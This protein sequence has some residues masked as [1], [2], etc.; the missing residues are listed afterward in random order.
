MFCALSSLYTFFHYFM[1]VKY[2]TRMFWLI[3]ILRFNIMMLF[4]KYFLNMASEELFKRK[5]YL[6]FKTVLWITY[7]FF[8]VI[9]FSSGGYALWDIS[10]N[11]VE[12][13]DLCRKIYYLSLRWGPFV[14]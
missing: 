5:Q 11:E 13:Q 3:E 12:G 14:A 9:M 1:P 2:R 6:K 4:I 7:G 8:T 10:S